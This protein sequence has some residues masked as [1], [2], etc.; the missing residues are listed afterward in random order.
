MDKSK[1]TDINILDYMNI[2]KSMFDIHN[3]GV[4]ITDAQGLIIYYNQ[5]QSTMD[6]TPLEQAIGQKICDLYNV[7]EKS[8]PTM[9][10]VLTGKPAF[11]DVHF[12]RTRRGK[13]VN[14]SCR[15]YPLILEGRLCGA[16][17]FIQPYSYMQLGVLEALK[18]STKKPLM[19][20]ARRDP[21][22]EQSKAA[23]TKLDYDF[24]TI[25]G[26]NRQ[27]Q[28]VIATAKQ[29]AKTPSPVLLIGE[30]GVGKEVFAR[31]IHN[32]SARRAEQFTAINCSA[33]P[34][35]LLEG[36]L[37]GTTK[38]AFTGAV[39]KPGLFEST[40]RG[41]I[42]LDEVDSMPVGLQSK[43]LRVL[44]ERKIRRVGDLRERAVDIKIIS[45]IG[46]SPAE[47]ISRGILRKDFYYRI[48]VV[49][50]YI[51]TLKERMEDLPLLAHHFVAKHCRILGI[52]EP[53]LSPE[54][55]AAFARY[56]WPGN[57]RE[58][59]HVLE[60]C[61]NVLEDGASIDIDHLRRVYPD[62][63]KFL[64][65]TDLE[66]TAEEREP[67][68]WPTVLSG[69]QITELTRPSGP[70]QQRRP[71]RPEA[72]K[73]T[74]PATL[75]EKRNSLEVETIRKSLQSAAGNIANAARLLGI[76]PQLL[77]YKLKKYGL[78][79]KEYVPTRLDPF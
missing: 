12:Y 5:A 62:L 56:D 40:H 45:S 60:A 73:P 19:A 26:K 14:S 48:G 35:S 57:V 31:S 17:S 11:D 67:I 25:V 29:A 39:E 8:S 22:G 28:E 4:L 64:H 7:D 37:F 58:M 27:L 75:P 51:P 41:T 43:L 72:D 71:D 50:L 16:L 68:E 66:A 69:G 52:R 53:L 2:F 10:V 47:G 1:R 78:K 32:H 20:S 3:E 13:L 34:E 65:R 63:F 15:I 18:A 24:S 9:Q 70:Q 30:T 76:S 54:V 61:L 59:E 23:A 79:A 74:G 46:R 55:M 77:H 36:I 44:Q 42:F 49:Q 38:G 33:V 21:A 6:E